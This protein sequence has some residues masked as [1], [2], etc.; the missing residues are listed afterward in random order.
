MN[1]VKSEYTAQ[2]PEDYAS[3]TA[4]SV[5]AMSEKQRRIYTDGLEPDAMGWRG[6]EGI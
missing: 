4:Q 1:E 5:A 6:K 3:G 2:M